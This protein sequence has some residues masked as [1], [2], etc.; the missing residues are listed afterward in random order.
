MNAARP[1][2]AAPI[3]P[4]DLSTFDIWDAEQAQNIYAIF[5]QMLETGPLTHTNT[6]G[7]HWVITDYDAVRAAGQDWETFTSEQ[8]VQ[9]PHIGPTFTPPITVDPPRHQKYRKPLAPHFSPQQVRRHEPAIRQHAHDLIDQFVERGEADLAGDFGEWLV[10]L[11]FFADVLHTPEDHL[12]EFVQKFVAPGSTPKEH[13]EVAPVVAQELIN[14]R[15]AGPPAGDVVDAVLAAEIDGRSLTEDEILGVVVLLLLGGTD[16]TRNVITSALHHIALHGDV[17]ELLLH[18]PERTER[19]VE[20][21]L[22]LYASVQTIGRTVTRQ[23]TIGDTTLEPGDKVVCAL[24][25]ANRDPAVF[26][27]PGEYAIDRRANPHFAFGVGPHRCLGSNLARLEIRVALEV[28][29]ERLPGYRLAPGWQFRRRRGFVHGPET[30]Q[31][32]FTPGERRTP[33]DVSPF[34]AVARA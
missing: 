8:G 22:R 34:R 23:V 21:F 24:A 27:R 30:L 28:V 19:A 31:V 14:L 2:E 12:Q 16:T 25:A 11:V 13:T 9:V 20:E 26:E 4:I 32:T 29:L 1:A 5:D 6:Y 15:R 3:D 17:R 10:P 18:E 7:G 33:S